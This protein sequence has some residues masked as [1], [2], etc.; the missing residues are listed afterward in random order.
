MSNNREDR[1]YN[2]YVHVYLAIQRKSVHGKKRCI[3]QVIKDEELDL[4]ILEAK[5]K[6]IGGQWRI[7]KT[8]NRRDTEKSGKWV[9]KHLIDNPQNASFLDSV[10]KTALLQK[11]CKVDKYFMFDVDTQ[12]ESELALFEQKLGNNNI[13]YNQRIKS[14]KGYHYITPQFDTRE[15]CELDYVTLLRDGYHFVKEIKNESKISKRI[16]RI[17]KDHLR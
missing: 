2:K 11:E 15:V 17:R 16:T 13:A 5:V 6:V 14:P 4:K 1:I 9:I 7:H 3:R 12:K 8:V 10:W